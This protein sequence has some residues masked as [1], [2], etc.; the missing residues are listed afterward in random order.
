[1]ASI[2]TFQFL[3]SGNPGLTM[4]EGSFQVGASGAVTA[5][6]TI[7]RYIQSVTRLYVGTYQI[8]L[9]G[10]YNRLVGASFVGIAG[11]TGNA[12]AVGSLSANTTYAITTVGN[13]AWTAIAG[14]PD[15]VTAAVGVTFVATGVGT[16]SG[17]AK[18]VGTVGWDHAELMGNP[19]QMIHPSDPNGALINFQTVLAGSVADP[20]SGSAL[21]FNLMLRNSSLLGTGETA[22]NY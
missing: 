9:V 18:A 8:K 10:N 11:V 22:D 6:T 16:G 15:Q 1:M 14:Y 4:M 7:G 3:N 12:V 17:F 2:Q 5:N 21:R 19:N 20:T 13:T